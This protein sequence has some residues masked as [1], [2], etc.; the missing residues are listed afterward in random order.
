L[1]K[2]S[3]PTGIGVLG[4][5]GFL[6]RLQHGSGCIHNN[7]RFAGENKATTGIEPV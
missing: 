1:R 5:D 6:R 4:V 3:A 7:R 2:L